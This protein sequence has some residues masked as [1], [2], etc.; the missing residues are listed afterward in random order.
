VLRRPAH[1]TWQFLRATLGR[2][3]AEECA[4][5]RSTLTPAQFALFQRMPRC[6]QRH[7]LDVFYTLH[8]AGH[9]D[10]ALLRA[11]LI[12]DVGKAG[13]RLTVWH[14]VAVVLM[15]ALVPGWLQR[16]GARDRGWRAPFAVHVRHAGQGAR[17][18]AEAGCSADVVRLIRRHHSSNPKD[19]RLALL[20]W[21]DERN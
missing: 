8:R 19:R 18:A 11:A 20:V 1:R 7:C 9:R 2:V 13:G 15:N 17:W 4:L 14:R 3:R 16:L 21:A 12:H 10:D 5:A 6:D